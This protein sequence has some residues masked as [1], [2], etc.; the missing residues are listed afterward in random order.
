MINN[1]KIYPLVCLIVGVTIISVGIYTLTLGEPVME[2]AC[3]IGGSVVVLHGIVLGVE[4]LLRHKQMAKDSVKS[5][6]AGALLNVCIGVM[7]ILLP[8]ITLAPIY[9]IF[10]IYILVNAAIKL[11][12]YFID[13]KDNVSGRLKE[14]VLFVFFLV[15]GVLMVFVPGMGKRGFLAVSG[16]YCIIYGAFMVWDFVF[17]C[18]PGSFRRKFSKKL[19]LPMPVLL[20]T[21]RPFA[22]FKSRQRQSLLAPE[23]VG[24]EL[25]PF[26]PEGKETDAPPD[27]EVM[28]HIS[29]HGMGIMGHCDICFEGKVYSYGSYDLTSTSLFGGIG[30]GIFIIGKR[31]PY[32]RFYVTATQREIYGYGF[33]LNEEQKLAVR[34]E[35]AKLTDMAYP[36]ETPL[37]QVHKNDPSAKG[38]AVYDWGSK[39]WNCTGSDFYKFKSGKMKTYFVVTSNCV[40]MADKIV[41]KACKDITPQRSVLTPGAYYDYLEHLLA[42]VGSPVFCRTIYNKDTTA[43]W[44]YT[45]RI[46]YSSPEMEMMTETE[47]NRRAAEKEGKKYEKR[48]NKKRH[49]RNN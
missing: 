25:K 8:K 2:F 17:Q 18:L 34:D 23:K 47:A 19:S 20:S 35:I 1:S 22:K 14:L 24:T 39:M 37:Q 26:F 40:M 30:D 41:R 49:K 3:Y 33:R 36:W 15:F 6:S 28:I 32:I 10:T 7:I 27:M 48:I 21:M 46:P 29:E 31:E 11:V 16:I 9:V 5:I 12:D 45:P 38:E 42:M 4:V 44:R 43:G 13:R